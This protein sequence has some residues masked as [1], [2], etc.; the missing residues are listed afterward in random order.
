[1]PETG[2]TGKKREQHAPDENASRK[3]GLIM[4]N[5]RR[6]AA[7]CQV[8][9]TIDFLPSVLELDCHTVALAT[10]WR[11]IWRLL[12]RR[13]AAAAEFLHLPRNY[14]VT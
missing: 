9:V 10:L 12:G 7:R 13:G 8:A 2:E 3:K 11:L 1:M 5:V 14:V 6:A 4:E